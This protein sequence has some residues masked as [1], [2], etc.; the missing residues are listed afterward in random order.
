MPHHTLLGHYP[1]RGFS[2]AQFSL[3]GTLRPLSGGV[4]AAWG[5]DGQGKE[6]DPSLGGLWGQPDF[7]SFS[8]W[9][10]STAHLS[11]GG[12]LD[13]HSL[14]KDLPRS[15]F[16]SQIACTHRFNKYWLITC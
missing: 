5:R 16:G 1:P 4:V 7:T 15:P 14:S 8:L 6:P 13:P 12:H 2:E 9:S 10:F 3:E 11:W